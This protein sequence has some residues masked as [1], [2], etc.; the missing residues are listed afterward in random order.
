[1]AGI[2]LSLEYVDPALYFPGVYPAR[3]T[4][5]VDEPGLEDSAIFVYHAQTEDRSIAGDIFECVASYQQ[6]QE[7]PVDAPDTEA[8][9]PIPYYRKSVVEFYLTDPDEMAEIWSIVQFDAK[10]LVTSARHWGKINTTDTVTID[11]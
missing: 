7:L 1:M 6:M 11:P 2:S 4:A 5:V 10:H 9:V 8:E 3:I